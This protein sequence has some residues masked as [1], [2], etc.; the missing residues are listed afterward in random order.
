MLYMLA[1]GMVMG[2]AG[3]RDKYYTDALIDYT[4]WIPLFRDKTGIPVDALNEAI[5]ERKHLLPCIASFDLDRLSGNIQMLPCKGKTRAVT[6]PPNR[7]GKN[8]VAALLRAPLPLSLLSCIYFRSLEDMQAFERAA[9]DVS[10][11]D[12]SSH[13]IEVF[14]PRFLSVRD[15]TWPPK[16][17]GVE[18]TQRDSPPAF[19]FALG[20]VLAMLYHTA[21][22][23]D[24]GV[25]AFRLVTEAACDSVNELSQDPILNELPNWMNGGKLSGQADTRARLFWGV[26]QSLVEAQM[27]ERPQ[28]PV[29]VAL[30]HLEKQ[31]GCLQ[32]TGFQTRLRQLIADMRGCLGLGGGTVTELFERHKGSLSRSLLLFCLREHCTDLLEFSHPLLSDAEYIT[33][34]ILFGVRDSWLQLPKDMR[35]LDLSAYVSCRMI[36]AEHRKQDDK[37]TLERPSCPKPLRQLFTSASGEWNDKQKAVALDLAKKSNWNDCIQTHITLAEGDL[38]ESFKREGLQVVLPGKVTTREK[39]D[40][41]KFM[42]RLGQWPPVDLQIQSEIRKNFV[43]QQEIEKKESRNGSSCG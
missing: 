42:H 43:S 13:H 23:N 1:A 16:G 5:K 15:M 41:A 17:V 32:E 24:Q 26:V 38:P 10:N 36:E 37:L 27:Q 30:A 25:A 22:R 9:G 29:D 34:G 6:S 4:G 2:P 3:F 28:A 20:G 14:E 19:G 11:I 33:A 8:E 35:D 12:L 7:K 40:K 31:L 18:L 21:N 39:V